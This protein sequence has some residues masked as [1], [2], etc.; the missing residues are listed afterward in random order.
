MKYIILQNSIILW[1]GE[2][3]D[4]WDALNRIGIEVISDEDDGR[5]T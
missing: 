4:E 1:E 2:A 5:V 3:R